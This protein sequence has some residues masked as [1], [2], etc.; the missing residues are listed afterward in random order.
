MKKT[1]TFLSRRAAVM[2]LATLLFTLT[3]QTAWAAGDIYVGY[4]D[5]TA[6][7]IFSD[8]TQMA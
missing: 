1:I 7:R 5:P 6:P 8:D 4:L 3:A 2:L